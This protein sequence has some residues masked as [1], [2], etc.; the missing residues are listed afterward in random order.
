M[1]REHPPGRRHGVEPARESS[2]RAGGLVAE[3]QRAV[4]HERRQ[5]LGVGGPV[6]AGLGLDAG[7]RA[8]RLLGLDHPHR[9]AVHE[10]HVVGR[11]RL[12]RHLPHGHPLRRSHR[13]VLVVLHRPPAR[14]QLLVD[15]HTGPS[16]GSEI[17]RRSTSGVNNRHGEVMR[18][19]LIFDSSD[20]VAVNQSTGF[21]PAFASIDLTAWSKWEQLGQRHDDRMPRGVS[22][23]PRPGRS[24]LATTGQSLGSPCERAVASSSN[25]GVIGDLEDGDIRLE[26]LQAL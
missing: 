25:R 7:E 5:L 22:D 10:Q 3:R 13:G 14:A 19:C 20:S 4:H 12:G 6:L 23:S 15:L 17:V 9:L 16:L 11:A 24:S 2:L 18:T 26:V 1:E 21:G 8:A